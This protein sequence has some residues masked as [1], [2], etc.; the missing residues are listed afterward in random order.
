MDKTIVQSLA[1][2]HSLNYLW[3]SV[4][5]SVAPLP[6]YLDHGIACQ[7]EEALGK[8]QAALLS[9]TMPFATCHVAHHPESGDSWPPGP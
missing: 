2:A 7:G 3:G 9:V 6:L 5:G 1:G 4:A 8:S